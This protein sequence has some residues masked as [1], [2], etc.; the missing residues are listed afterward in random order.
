R[1]SSI[2]AGSK[3]TPRHTLRIVFSARSRISSRSE[4]SHDV[5]ERDFMDG[6][7]TATRHFNSGNAKDAAQRIV[8]LKSP[9]FRDDDVSEPAIQRI[10]PV[11]IPVVVLHSL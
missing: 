5:F 10:S 11:N 4:S 3:S 9:V 7:V 1:D 6:A 2:P 8:V